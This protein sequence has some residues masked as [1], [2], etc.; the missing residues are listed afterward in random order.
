MVLI[1]KFRHKVVL[2]LL[3][4][5]NALLK[6]LRPILQNNQIIPNNQFGFRNR[7][8][9]IH[10]VHRLTDEISTALEN[11]EYCSELFLDIAQAFD[12]V[13]HDG[14]LYKLKLFMPAPYYLI[15]K[16]Y[17]QNRSFVVRQGNDISSTHSIYAEV[18]HG[19]DLSP[20]LYNIFTADI[21]QSCNTFL[22][23]YADGTAILSSSSNPILASAAIQD[24]A[25]KIDEWAKKWKIKIN[26]DKSVQVAFTLKQSPRE[27]PQLTMNNAP[28]PVQTECR[29]I[30]R[31]LLKKMKKVPI[32]L[33]LI[34][35]VSCELIQ[36]KENELYSDSYSNPGILYEETHNH[37]NDELSLDK[38]PFKIPSLMK[39]PIGLLDNREIDLAD[40]CFPKPICDPLTKYRTIN[41]SCNN[42]IFPIWGQ[43]N[44]ANTRIIQADYSDGKS[45][46][47][48]SISGKKLPNPRK[49][50]TTLFPDLN[51]PTMKYNLL[52]MQ[53]GQ[54]T[55]HDTELI[56]SKSVGNDGNPI[57]CCNPD[58]STPEILPQ[59]CLQIT[60]PKDENGYS[61]KRCL[62][63]QR[64]TDTADLGCNIKPVRQQIGVTS[65][66][67][68]SL[69]YGSDEKTARS[70][71]T[72]SHGKLRR[73]IGPKGKS[74]LPNVKQ[75]TKE[76]TV[77]NDMTV[78]Y[79]AGDLRVN[80]HPNIA[81]ST[82]SLLRIHN[83]LC[84]EFVKINP[85]WKD[86]RI[87]QEARR[88]LIAMYQHVVYYEFVP[89]LVGKDYAKANKL[90][91]LE[92]GYNMDYDEFLNPTTI[93]S[94][95]GA[96]YRSLHS[97]IQGYMDLINEARKVTSKIRLSD[98][99]LRTD[100]VQRGDNYDS[101][102]RGL[103]SQISQEQDQYFTSEVSEYL[104]RVPNK[105]EGFD[106]PSF[107]I[108][109]GRDFGEPSYNKF[110]QLCGLSEAKTFDDFT[111]QIS[112]KNVDTL[113][114]LYEDP[115][116][117]DFY[118]GGL[119]EKQKP[120]SLLGHTFQCISGEMFFRWKFGDR[121]FYEFGNQT[122]S[123]RPDQLDEIRKSTLS[124]FICMSS[125]IQSI[126]RD[127]F[128][129]LSKQNPLVP[130]SSLPKINLDLWK[131]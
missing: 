92:K 3:K 75:A 76:C 70:L 88:L 5:F 6:R 42:L 54:V 55:A 121:F 85:E 13:W 45:K 84:D 24:H 12:K 102:T 98:F 23:T 28:I 58:G 26:T 97:E 118:V 40:R 39:N 30:R 7:H 36:H 57:L 32:V 49:I 99:F 101:F 77:S 94:F 53:F 51:R 80:Q 110:R 123:F 124:L 64:A 126:Q 129:V 89:R 48:K 74:Y 120:G 52:F 46:E 25:N 43:S 65:F 47:R 20:D 60:I 35:S 62:S 106:L 50:R 8:S 116:D 71:R 34:V 112:K 19:S 17:L 125:D 117:V 18:P 4:F 113:A 63:S 31:Y 73:Q 37:L 115:N 38:N 104:F 29:L 109:R 130:C 14:L 82:I 81:V 1:K 33:A 56:F 66:M 86:E 119:L 59:D 108:A 103:L 128:D 44:S 9:T 11:K 131:E 79:A 69:L 122:G 114:S 22:A 2:E 72:F 90:L 111:D 16:S 96:A 21:P 87:Y 100:I 83:K 127:A 93:T 41:G 78:C 15:I 68:A 91:P 107:D 105:T 61:K 10:Q 67:D 27:C 95:T